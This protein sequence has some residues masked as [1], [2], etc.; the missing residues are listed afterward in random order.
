[1]LKEG[2]SLN[3]VLAERLKNGFTDRRFGCQIFLGVNPYFQLD[4]HNSA[5]EVAHYNH[6][7]PALIH[8]VNA[9]ERVED[10]LAY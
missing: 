5:S 6:M 2:S 1:M 3:V 8:A 7:F 9:E 4:S 10:Y